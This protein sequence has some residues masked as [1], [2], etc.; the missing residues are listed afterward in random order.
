MIAVYFAFR[1]LVHHAYEYK[2]ARGAFIMEGKEYWQNPYSNKPDE[3]FFIKR[4]VISDSEI[5]SV[6]ATTPDNLVW[7]CLRGPRKIRVHY[8]LSGGAA[9]AHFISLQSI[10]S[11]FDCKDSSVAAA[12]LCNIE[13]CLG[14]ERIENLASWQ[15]AKSKTRREQA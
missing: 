7:S 2:F 10:K 14:T 4:I 5:V 15:L 11:D 13:D 6:R 9:F 12:L 8:R 1:E 3:L